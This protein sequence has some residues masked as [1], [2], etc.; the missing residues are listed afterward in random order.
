MMNNSMQARMHS[1]EYTSIW[2]TDCWSIVC[3]C[4]LGLGG[5]CIFYVTLSN[6]LRS[7]STT[8]VY[9]ISPEYIFGNNAFTII[10][11]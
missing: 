7:I 9:G 10:Q 3:K 4:G 11:L 8:N 1:R 5:N 6:V 2:K